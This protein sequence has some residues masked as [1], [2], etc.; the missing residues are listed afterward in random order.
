MG[1]AKV[2]ECR[3]V[4][5]VVFVGKGVSDVAAKHALRLARG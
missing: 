2:R 5:D 3:Y 1:P 4:G